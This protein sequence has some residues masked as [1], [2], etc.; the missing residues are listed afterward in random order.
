MKTLVIR[1]SSAGDIILTSLF[2]RA[3]RKRF[4]ESSITYLTKESFA[5]LVQGSPYID[6]VL[7]IQNHAGLSEVK[8]LRQGLLREEYD[9]VFDL[10]NSLRS[11]LVRLGLGR[12]RF[13]FKKPTFKKWLLVRLKINHLRPIVP[14][15]ERYLQVGKELGLVNDH[16]GLDVSLEPF[17]SLHNKDITYPLIV[18]APGSQH[19]TKRW[20]AERYATLGQQIL[21]EYNGTIVLLGSNAELETCQQVE[22]G[23]QSHR[24][25]INLAGKTTLTQAATVIQNASLV[26]ANDSALGHVAAG[27]K[28]P[29]LSIFGS[30]VEE[31]GFAPYASD[32]HVIQNKELACRPCT[33]I[34]RSDCPQQH[35]NCM[36]SISTDVVF[37]KVKQIVG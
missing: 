23:I 2:V 22:Q 15:P 18:F 14:I 20:P 16:N 8:A 19:Y 25:V 33:P 6:T 12:K 11:K 21:N 5:S 7:T 37:K 30:T 17:D 1:F 29:L 34:G 31:F 9:L 13:I 28:V 26:I 4:P 3:L 32:V 36:L 27:C 24:E 10:H 35:F